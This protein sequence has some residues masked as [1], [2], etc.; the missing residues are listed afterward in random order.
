MAEGAGGG[1]RHY[2]LVGALAA[3]ATVA[4]VFVARRLEP[5]ETH[6]PCIDTAPAGT[7][8]TTEAPGATVAPEVVG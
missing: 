1:L 7:P 2:G 5:A 3:V 8:G 6:T 4:S